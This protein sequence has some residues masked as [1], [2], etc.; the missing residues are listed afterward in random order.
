[1]ASLEESRSPLL[2]SVGSFRPSLTML[3]TSLKPITIHMGRKYAW[4][5][6]SSMMQNA[7]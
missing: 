3:Q 2:T 6:F 5:L 1:M 7:D 4:V